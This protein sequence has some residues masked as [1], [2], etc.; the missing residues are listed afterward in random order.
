[1]HACRTEAP[2]RVFA[3]RIVVPQTEGLLES[4]VQCT[5]QIVVIQDT[6]ELQQIILIDRAYL[7]EQNHRRFLQTKTFSDKDVRREILLLDCGGQRS[8]DDCWTILVEAV[9]LKYQDRP[10]AALD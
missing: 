5:D 2:Y 3:F 6:D 9:I 4:T 10:S 7:F 8:D 1:M